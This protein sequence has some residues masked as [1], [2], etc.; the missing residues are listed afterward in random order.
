[1]VSVLV[2]VNEVEL[3]TMEVAMVVEI[4]T[5]EGRRIEGSKICKYFQ[6]GSSSRPRPLER[7]FTPISRDVILD[8]VAGDRALAK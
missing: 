3:V 8:S 6:D 7:A 1:M 5:I 4:P 2:V